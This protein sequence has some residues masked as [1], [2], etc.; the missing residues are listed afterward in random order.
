MFAG[1]SVLCPYHCRDKAAG[2]KKLSDP[3][4]RRQTPLFIEA[5][6]AQVPEHAATKEG[7]RRNRN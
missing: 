5:D 1:H 4:L 6:G 3:P 7:V 2:S